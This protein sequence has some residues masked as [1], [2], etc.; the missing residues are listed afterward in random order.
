MLDI[1]IFDVDHGFSAAINLHDHHVILLDVG[2]NLRNGF[3][4]WQYA[5]EQNCSTIDCLILPAYIRE[6][7]D[8]IPDVLDH[9]S[10]AG[11]TVDRLVTNPTLNVEQFPDLQEVSSWAH[12][13]LALAASHHPE[14]PRVSH[15]L[16]IDDIHFFFF[17][18]TSE[19]CQDVRDLSLVT[20][21]EYED[22]NI[23][24]P[25]D[26]KTNGWKTLLK[27]E[28]FRAKLRRVNLFVASNHGQEDGYCSEVFDYCRPELI[29]ISNEG[30]QRS[31]PNLLDRYKT[32]AKG[33]AKGVLNS[34]GSVADQYHKVLTTHDNGTIAISKCLDRLRQVTTEPQRSES[35]K[36]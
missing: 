23:I 29:L 9:L 14:C 32:H 24:L 36:V 1:K 5:I 34:Q 17:W 21:L 35:R 25:S 27:Y 10:E 11:I 13:P 31:L 16:T 8:G 4:S 18:N 12:N 7:L 30:N 26:L 19:T 20:F 15:S 33:A 28:E 2:S 22:I 6:H 3:A